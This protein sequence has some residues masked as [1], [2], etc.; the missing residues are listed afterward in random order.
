MLSNALGTDFD[1]LAE[2]ELIEWLRRGTVFQ[3]YAHGRVAA[4]RSHPCRLWVRNDSGILCYSNLATRAKREKTIPLEDIVDVLLGPTSDTFKRHGVC[5]DEGVG[6]FSLV[7]AGRT[8]DLRAPSADEVAVWAA[9][10]R[11]VV[12][13]SRLEAHARRVALRAQPRES[14]CSRLPPLVPAARPRL[15][16]LTPL[17]L[18]YLL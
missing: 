7:F 14:E 4:Q 15:L 18:S 10:F 11:Q 2:A 1:D 16:S 8:L 17:S 9:Y 13:R 6:C 12:E 5:G 3:K